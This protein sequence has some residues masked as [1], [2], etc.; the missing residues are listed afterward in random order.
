MD[1]L[2]SIAIHQPNYLPWFGYFLKIYLAD[3]FVFHD[4]VQFSKSSFT[5][6]VKLP[7]KNYTDTFWLSL[8]TGK[9]EP[10]INEVVINEV[11]K[12]VNIH[13]KIIES[14]YHNKKYFN[15]FFPKLK[16]YFQEALV[17]N[18]LSDFNISLVKNIAKYL[19]L[20]TVFRK[21]SSLKKNT[22]ISNLAIVKLLNGNIYLSG[23]GAKSYQNDISFSDQGIEL[24]YLESYNFITKNSYHQ[25]DNKFINGLSIID[26]IMNIGKEETIK[27][28]Q[29]FES[30]YC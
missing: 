7:T 13:L 9:D 8:T 27:M 1:N 29:K 2:K 18:L 22:H 10:K 15:A 11:Q 24:C 19:E 17:H 6:R 16:I 23:T 12:T 26:I 28:F 3:T 21:S 5:K 25:S 14:T 20:E 4:V 30:K